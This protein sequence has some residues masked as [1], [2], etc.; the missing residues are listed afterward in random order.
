MH[1]EWRRAARRA[2]GCI[3]VTAGVVAMFAAIDVAAAPQSGVVAKYERV[4]VSKLHN[5]FAEAQD[6]EEDS[7]PASSP[8]PSPGPIPDTAAGAQAEAQAKASAEAQE[9]AEAESQAKTEAAEQKA[10][11]R[12]VTAAPTSAASHSFHVVLGS[13]DRTAL[14]SQVFASPEPVD[15]TAFYGTPWIVWDRTQGGLA[16]P[17]EPGAVVHLTGAIDGTYRVDGLIQY[18]TAETPISQIARG[19]S[20]TFQVCDAVYGHNRMHIVGLTKIG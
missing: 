12:A 8:L 17:Q 7:S 4:L 2:L 18:A 11:A 13:A 15:A 20:L 16:F 19:T 14:Q 9:K 3:A 1:L 10:K 5:G 6:A